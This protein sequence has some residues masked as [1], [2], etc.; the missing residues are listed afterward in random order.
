M[1]TWW[2]SLTPTEQL[3]FASLLAL[4]AGFLLS[5]LFQRSREQTRAAIASGERARVE[6]RL[7]SAERECADLKT[8]ALP[9]AEEK[10]RQ[11]ETRVDEL[12]REIA[13]LQAREAEVTTR[14]EEERQQ[15][16]EKL[17]E[18]DRARDTFTSVFKA[19]S[20]DALRE[21]N[22]SFLA[23]ARSSFEKLQQSAQGDLEKRQTAIQQ[24]VKP[25]G[26]SL[27][28]FA[29]HLHEVEKSRGTAYVELRQQVR[30][31][32]ESETRLQA[33]TANL[34]RALGKPQV[35]GRWGELQLRRVVELAGM[36]QYCDFVEQAS[37]DTGDGRQ[38]P[39]L[40]VR[41]P[42]GKTIVVDAKTPLSAYLE[43]VEAE[44]D[45]V[46]A[47]K[48]A[49]HARHVST[50]ALELSRK[51]YW[52][53][54]ENTPEFVVLFL[55][56]ENFFSAAVQADPELIER[57]VTGRVILAT[58]TTLISLLRA[59][60]FGWRQEVMSENAREACNLGA[61]L[62][63]RIATLAE[64]FSSLGG[65][66]GK[67]VEHYNKAMATLDTRVIVT[68]RRLGELQMV[69]VDKPPE[70]PSPIDT[71]PRPLLSEEFQPGAS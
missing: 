37:V 51:A 35:R 67:A 12:M 23:L 53:Q 30:Q 71:L 17:A 24:L 41:L 66:L 4:L 18:L 44:D 22:E 60:A 40:V 7:A 10:I 31:L 46:R 42:A 11:R 34:V 3:F 19:L 58:P 48:L 49:D 25:V 57:A 27:D 43:A 28:K 61:E 39:D 62:Y 68:A 9:A 29:S 26:E 70:A 2:T 5:W 16:A 15:A 56:G 13:E 69:E 52:E 20:A 50:H 65:Q 8:R 14:L 38:R 45:G 63:R 36:L 54:F 32:M 64:H 59:V 47:Q 21:S 55:P 1:N 6:E 33:E